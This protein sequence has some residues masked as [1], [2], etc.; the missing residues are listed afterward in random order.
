VNRSLE[1]GEAAS[2]PAGRVG[3][4]T[5][6]PPQFGHTPSK[7]PRAQSAQNV[8]SKVQINALGAPFGRSQSQQSQ[9]GCRV[10]TARWLQRDRPASSAS[11]GVR[12][13]VE[14]WAS[15]E[16]GCHSRQVAGRLA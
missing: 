16:T 11:V 1:A 10:S 14:P 15:S 12:Y 3:R 7:R 8:H 9:L 2:L 6:L 4:R 5:R 13:C